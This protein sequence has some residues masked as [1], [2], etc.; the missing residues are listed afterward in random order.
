MG[1]STAVR[2]VVFGCVGRESDPMK[3]TGGLMACAAIRGLFWTALSMAEAQKATGKIIGMRSDRR[4][5]VRPMIGTIV[6]NDQVSPGIF[7][8]LEGDYVHALMA[9]GR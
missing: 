1:F 7:D 3:R 8:E 6:V 4:R 5:S 2:M 9:I